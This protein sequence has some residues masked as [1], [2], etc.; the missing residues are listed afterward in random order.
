MGGGQWSGQ[1][2]TSTTGGVSVKV[3]QASNGLPCKGRLTF[4]TAKTMGGERVEWEVRKSVDGR[5]SRAY[6]RR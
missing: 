2:R 1:L 5:G 3:V 6:Q 4:S